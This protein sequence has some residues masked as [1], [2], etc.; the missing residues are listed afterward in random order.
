MTTKLADVSA[1][2]EKVKLCHHDLDDLL[3]NLQNF[4]ILFSWKRRFLSNN[5][6]KR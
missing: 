5:G 2:N 6:L 1:L 3:Q 4:E